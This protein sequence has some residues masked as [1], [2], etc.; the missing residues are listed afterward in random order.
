[1]VNL[2]LGAGGRAAGLFW[3]VK[4]NLHSENKSRMTDQDADS[5]CPCK[6]SQL[7]FWFPSGAS[8]QTRNPVDASSGGRTLSHG[9]CTW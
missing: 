4:C 3:R 2:A 7:P 1:M 5:S 9:K 8:F 6:K